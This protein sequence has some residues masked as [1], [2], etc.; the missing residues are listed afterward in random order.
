[1]SNVERITITLTADMAAAVHAAVSGGEDASSSEIVRE[2]LRD[3]RHRR[4]LRERERA[5]LR[6]DIQHG[7]EDIEAGRVR[8]V[9]PARIIERGVANSQI[10]GKRSLRGLAE[11]DLAEIWAFI[12]ADNPKAA[13]AFPRTLRAPPFPSRA[14][15]GP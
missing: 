7:L 6:T 3:W 4:V 13:G 12:A 10:S 2:A 5:E 14:R 8:D 15:P 11:D 9:D 1:M